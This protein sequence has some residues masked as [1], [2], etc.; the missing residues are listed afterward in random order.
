MKTNIRVAAA[1]ILFLRFFAAP[2]SAQSAPFD[3]NTFRGRIAYSADGN[4]NDEDDWAASPVALAILAAFGARE[5]LVHFDYN[6]I[7]P[8]THP[9]WEDTHRAGV[10]G[11]A[12]RYGYRQSIF[13]DDQHDLEGALESIK[14]A[15]NESTSDN[16]LYFIVAGPMEVPYRGIERSDPDKRKF[17]YLISHSRWN[18]GFAT[19]DSFTYNKRSV[20]PLGAHWIQIQDQNRFLSTSPFGRP[21]NDD[22]WEPWHW[23]RDS[24]DPNV[25]F[26]WERLRAS[27]RADCS[28]AGMAYFLMTGDELSE[29]HKLRGLLEGKAV[30]APTNPRTQVRLEAENFLDLDQYEIEFRNDRAVSHRINVQLAG[31]ARGRIRTPFLEPYTAPAA[32]YD[33]EVRY[34]DE[35]DGQSR[36]TLYVNNDPQG[37]SWT[38]SS[39]N[40]SWLTRTIPG[41]A[42]R[43]GDEI[44]VEIEGERGESGKLDYVQLNYKAALPR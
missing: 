24:G 30:P 26:L 32:W 42:I 11:A 15:I 20:I 13:H 12:K 28:D 9:E 4:Y 21:A 41:V 17:V 16:P 35:K 5:R 34:F 7:L 31:G 22:E 39:D 40:E 33:V 37:E 27:T 19:D 8:Q 29:I 44:A 2:L 6:S 18:D 10:L 36:L 1:T 38:A 3:G 23:M 43:A 25:Q 14:N